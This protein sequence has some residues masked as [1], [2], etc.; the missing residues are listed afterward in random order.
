MTKWLQAAIR[1]VLALA[2][3]GPCLPGCTDT[4][5][6]SSPMVADAGSD[7][8]LDAM[9]PEDSS[10]APRPADINDGRSLSPPDAAEAD[11]ARVCHDLSE[12]MIAAR[13]YSHFDSPGGARS[14]VETTMKCN[15]I[16]S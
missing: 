10:C 2:S 14:L 16:T 5:A 4:S 3:F 7:A 9:V 8:T 13:I 1:P 15:K 6:K 12:A 11:P